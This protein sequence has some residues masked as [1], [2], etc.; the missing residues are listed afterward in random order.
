MC[1]HI[2]FKVLLTI[3]MFGVFKKII[4]L[5][6][7]QALIFILIVLNW[8]YLKS[9]FNDKFLSNIKN[10]KSLSKSKTN[11]ENLDI[12]FYGQIPKFNP[13]SPDGLYV[14][15]LQS[16]VWDKLVLVDHNFIWTPNLAKEWMF[17]SDRTELKLKFN[18]DIFW[19]NGR[20]VDEADF[21]FSFFFYKDDSLKASI[22]KPILDRIYSVSYKD[23][24][25]TLILNSNHKQDPFYATHTYWSHILSTM[26]LYPKDL[27]SNPFMGTGPYKVD[28]FSN[29]GKIKFSLNDNSW[30]FKFYK[31]IKIPHVINVKSLTS[32]NVLAKIVEKNRGVVLGK[33]IHLIAMEKWFPVES[34]SELV[35]ISMNLK[36][37]PLKMRS[38]LYQLLTETNDLEKL[39]L[40]FKDLNIYGSNNVVVKSQLKK[41]HDNKTVGSFKDSKL[42]NISL[43]VIYDDSSDEVWLTYLKEK[44]KKSGVD[45]ILNK[46]STATL[47]KAIQDKKYT[48]YINK[49]ALDE[50]YP[51]YLSYHSMGAY[52]FSGWSNS[53]I[54]HDLER[55]IDLRSSDQIKAMI[56]KIKAEMDME[57]FE[58]PIFSYQSAV[59]WTRNP[60][61]PIQGQFQ[62][63][64]LIYKAIICADNL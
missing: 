3:N 25:L 23:H 30:F 12:Y 31:N 51:H 40:K 19:S 4:F 33:D 50:F 47:Y 10:N 61:K 59:L 7:F 1:C 38:Y 49:E 26:K 9:F 21:K 22:Y 46:M 16:L 8:S 29:R 17:N 54:D 36:K 34:S 5:N 57:F 27:K 41:R 55:M 32:E 53:A 63:L 35:S 6:F 37:V 44:L 60:C 14:W 2:S 45:L 24:E 20:K 15:W 48:S 56:K 13:I 52:N 11:S 42:K 62:G 43:D 64:G 58:V 28:S 18:S 39:N